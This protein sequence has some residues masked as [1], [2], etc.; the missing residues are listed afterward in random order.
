MVAS[1]PNA[2]KRL[3]DAPN[4]NHGPGPQRPSIATWL[5]PVGLISPN[6]RP[7]GRRSGAILARAMSR[8][9][10]DL[11]RRLYQ[12]W[13]R[14]DFN[15]P[16]FFD[17]DITH[18]RISSRT[19]VPIGDQGEWH[20]REDMWI[21]IRN[22]LRS[23]TDVRTTPE[24]FIDLGDRVLVLDRQTGFGRRSGV[25]VE[26]EVGNLFTVSDGRIVRWEAYWH[27]SDAIRAAG[28]EEPPA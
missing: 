19:D 7:T 17:P 15:T 12:H 13:E 28:L 11:L 5:A 4:G 3:A 8:E 27:R 14:G 25:P 2:A 23:W 26:Q 6:G 22:Y 9:A 1:L 20:G 21:S 24:R 16:E 18:V 10:V